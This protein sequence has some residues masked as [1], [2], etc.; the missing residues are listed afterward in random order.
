MSKTHARSSSGPARLSLEPRIAL[1]VAA[2]C[3]SYLIEVNDRLRL[4][5]QAHCSSFSNALLLEA[6]IAAEP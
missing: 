2:S 3:R 6:L 4:F 1:T 5:V